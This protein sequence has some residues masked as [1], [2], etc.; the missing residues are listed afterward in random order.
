MTRFPGPLRLFRNCS[1][2]VLLNPSGVRAALC[3]VV[4]GL[5]S[6]CASH[7]GPRLSATQE[8]A[9]YAAR[10]KHDYT[11]PGPPGDPWG[12]YVNEASKRFDV[13]ARWI[14]EVM[15]VE[16]GGK[17][18]INGGLVTSPVGAMGL[19]QIM[20]ETYDEM[21][22]EYGLGN[23]PYDPH[24]NIL[25]GAAYIRQMYDL[26]GS[27]GFLAAYNAGPG[28]LDDYLTRN[29]PLP[30]ET[31]HYV[32][33]IGP[34]IMGV[35]PKTPSVAVQYAM[36]QM[37]VNIPAGP[38]YPGYGQPGPDGGVSVPFADVPATAPARPAPAPASVPVEVAQLPDPPRPTP[39]PAPR[40]QFALTYTPPTPPRHVRFRLVTPAMADTLPPLPPRRGGTATGRWA[41]QVGAFGSQGQAHAAANAARATAH[42]GL[43]HPA[44]TT[45]SHAHTMLY[46]A[47]LTGLSRDAA[48]KACERLRGG[49]SGC[50]VLS[51]DAQS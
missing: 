13:P 8:A 50:M 31:R 16:S 6:A 15:H 30:A 38:R 49:H 21:R 9:Q 22:A 43:A 41:I 12:P 34:R 39:Q 32:A 29:R 44:V 27:P 1:G 20:P 36:N 17:E 45:V 11:P 7:S 2:H 42:L 26:Y 19:M 10:A 18:F 35:E 14:R 24:D 23:D 46:R 4:L 47:R 3:L 51:P 5:L 48:V 25:A 40:Q 37:P 33:M 28:R